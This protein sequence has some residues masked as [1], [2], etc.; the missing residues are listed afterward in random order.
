MTHEEMTAYVA[1][2]PIGSFLSVLFGYWLGS[3]AA[4]WLVTKISKSYDT[5]LLP[6]IVGGIFFL[7]G[8]ANFFVMLP[9]QPVWFIL[10]SLVG[11][12]G[13]ALLGHRIAKIYLRP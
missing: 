12:I 11:F 4:G 1:S 13:F 10:L 2:L 8:I 9:G 5:M 3:L 7:G 6:L